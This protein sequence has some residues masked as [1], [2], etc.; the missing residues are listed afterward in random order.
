MKI[1]CLILFLIMPALLMLSAG[2]SDS[3]ESENNLDLSS[4]GEIKCENNTL[5]DSIATIA[6]PI[7]VKNTDELLAY[8]SNNEYGDSAKQFHDDY[9]SM[10][11][12]VRECGYIVEVATEQQISLYKDGNIFLIPYHQYEDIGI[13]YSTLFNNKVYQV[14]INYYDSAVFS[15]NT[16]ITEYL[17]Y[18]FNDNVVKEVECNEK[19]ISLTTFG[20]T[21]ESRMICANF[22]IDSMYYCTIRTDATESELLN[23]ITNL[24]LKNK[25]LK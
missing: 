1:K 3:K 20:L 16:N 11:K 24:T 2:C 9:D 19:S 25:P 10:Y 15:Q 23:Y 6:Q 17:T 4:G 7:H 12:K 8:I 22:S 5:Q 18:R 14:L 13:S 21:D